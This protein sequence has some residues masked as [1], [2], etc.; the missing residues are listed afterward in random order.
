M[1]AMDLTLLASEKYRSAVLAGAAGICPRVELAS[2]LF[3]EI[4]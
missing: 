2:R 4:S 3:A 1:K